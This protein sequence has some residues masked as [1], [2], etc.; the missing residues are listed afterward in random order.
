MTLEVFSSL[1]DSVIVS[2]KLNK[3]PLFLVK[4]NGKPVGRFL[5]SALKIKGAKKEVKSSEIIF[6]VVCEWFMLFS[7]K[8]DEKGSACLE[9]TEIEGFSVRAN[10]VDG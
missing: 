9:C 10:H 4:H 6:A 5:R 1:N 7:C 8:G 2:H 3:F